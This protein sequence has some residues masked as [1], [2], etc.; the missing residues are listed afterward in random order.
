M[1]APRKRTDEELMVHVGDSLLSPYELRRMRERVGLFIRQMAEELGVS[2]RCVRYWEQ[3]ARPI[4]REHAVRVYLLH[5]QAIE[6]DYAP[7]KKRDPRK[8]RMRLNE[9]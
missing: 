8:R 6:G 5:R 2:P 1:P 4:P 3:G 7:L 9:V